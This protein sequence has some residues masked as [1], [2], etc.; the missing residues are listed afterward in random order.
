MCRKDEEFEDMCEI[1][2]EQQ[3]FSSKES[4]L[5]QLWEMLTDED[6]KELAKLE[7]EESPISWH[8]E[9][10]ETVA[11]ARLHTYDK[12]TLCESIVQHWR[13]GKLN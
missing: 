9:T 13:T 8:G 1:F 3:G 2:I 12:E 6:I 7:R 11:H 4:L 10:D 5:N